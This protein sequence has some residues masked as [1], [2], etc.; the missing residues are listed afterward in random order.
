VSGRKSG[1]SAVLR[2]CVCRLYVELKTFVRLGRSL[3]GGPSGVP[4]SLRDPVCYKD[5]DVQRPQEFRGEI[6]PQ[7]FY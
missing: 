1:L 5:G 6:R 4:A 7:E 3:E 2:V